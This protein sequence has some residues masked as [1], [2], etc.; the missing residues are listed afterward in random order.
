MERT[1]FNDATH[2]ARMFKRHTNHSPSD[3]R[4]LFRVPGYIVS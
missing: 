3:F 4:A 2:F 1:G